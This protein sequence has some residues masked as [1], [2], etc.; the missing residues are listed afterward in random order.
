MYIL[1]LLEEDEEEEDEVRGKM[2]PFDKLTI[3]GKF[4]IFLRGHI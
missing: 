1:L 2:F 4:K 3:P